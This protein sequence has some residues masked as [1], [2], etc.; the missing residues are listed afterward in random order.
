MAR[1]EA[2]DELRE[3]IKRLKQDLKAI[4]QSVGDTGSVKWEQISDRMKDRATE[5]YEQLRDA[6]EYARQRSAQATQAARETVSAHPL[7]WVFG[8]VGLGIILG[9]LMGR[10]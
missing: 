3:D 1:Q 2:L 6:A 10:K 5:G 4:L 7:S 9:K 8:A